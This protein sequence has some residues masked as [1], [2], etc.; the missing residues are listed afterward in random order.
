[1]K[2]ALIVL[3][4]L[5]VAGGVFAQSFSGNVKTGAI[6]AFGEDNPVWAYNGVDYDQ[7]AVKAELTFSNGGDDW[8]VSVGANGDV[9]LKEN[10]TG[11]I[12]IGDFKGWVKFADMFTLSAGKGVGDDWQFGDIFWMPMGGPLA[13]EFWAGNDHKASVKLEIE[14][15]SGLNFGFLFSYPNQGS[16][17][18]KL[19]DFFQETGIGAKYN[20]GIFEAFTTFELFS[21]ETTGAETDFSWKFGVN[22]PLGIIN[23]KVEGGFFEVLSSSKIKLGEKLYGNIV[24]LDWNVVSTQYITD[25]NDPTADIAVS[26]SYGIPI[27]DK[28]KATLGASATTGIIPSFDIDVLKWN[29]YGKVAYDFNGNVSTSGE[30]GLD[31]GKRS[32]NFALGGKVT[33]YLMWLVGYNF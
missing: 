17:A 13:A 4:I 2:K 27:N 28:A 9:P 8:G 26:L 24:G 3:L 20:A 23:V 19:V 12:Y 1:M 18:A 16:N 10:G 11:G 5:A 30:F 15:I 33:P 6:F 14:P 29:A 32:D 25:G 22:V 21:P 7:H 31:N